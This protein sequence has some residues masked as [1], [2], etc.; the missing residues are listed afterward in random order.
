MFQTPK[1]NNSVPQNNL[2]FYRNEIPS[3]PFP[4]K[5]LLKTETLAITK[6]R[7]QDE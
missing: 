3:R 5:H 1:E 2:L 6:I 4:G 7:L